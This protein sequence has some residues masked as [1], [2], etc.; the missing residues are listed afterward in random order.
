MKAYYSTKY[1]IN[2]KVYFLVFHKG[3]VHN[4]AS[5]PQS[6]NGKDLLIRGKDLELCWQIYEKLLIAYRMQN[7]IHMALVF[8]RQD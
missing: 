4:T 3:L 6:K 8:H 1:M 5:Q 2:L 7:L